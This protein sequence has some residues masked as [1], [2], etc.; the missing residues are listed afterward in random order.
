MNLYAIQVSAI[1]DNRRDRN[2]EFQRSK[3]NPRWELKRERKRQEALKLK[4]KYVRR[5]FFP[6]FYSCIVGQSDNG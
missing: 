4:E 2:L 3:E 1:E 6:F 5:V